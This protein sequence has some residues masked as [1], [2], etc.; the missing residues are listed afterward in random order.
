[1]KYSSYV[2]LVNDFVGSSLNEHA[3]KMV[4]RTEVLAVYILNCKFTSP[5]FFYI[6][7]GKSLLIPFILSYFK[8]SKG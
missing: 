3:K 4:S 8:C 6:Y 7:K 5:Y 2:H 1:M